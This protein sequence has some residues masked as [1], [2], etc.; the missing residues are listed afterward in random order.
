[1]VKTTFQICHYWLL[2]SNV[3]VTHFPKFIHTHTHTHTHSDNHVPCG[4]RIYQ[5]AIKLLE[6]TICEI[7]FIFLSSP[8]N[9]L[10]DSRERGREGEKHELVVSHT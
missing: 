7:S 3:G 6:E 8:K 10:I 9:V 5:N 1:M 2:A 4:S